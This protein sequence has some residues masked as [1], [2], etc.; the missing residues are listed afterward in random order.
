MR[1]GVTRM[2]P[3]PLGG[4]VPIDPTAMVLTSVIFIRLFFSPKITCLFSEKRV[5]GFT[6]S[7]LLSERSPLMK[8]VLATVEPECELPGF[9][10]RVVS[11]TQVYKT[12][13]ACGYVRSFEGHTVFPI[14]HS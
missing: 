10:G 14:R 5:Y 12:L 2:L 6:H 3:T 7:D 9:H 11:D 4:G 1:V 13:P 8:F